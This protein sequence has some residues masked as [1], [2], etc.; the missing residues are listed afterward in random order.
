[1]LLENKEFDGDIDLCLSISN[2]ALRIRVLF[3]DFTTSVA[4]LVGVG[5]G[6]DLILY[7]LVVGSVFSDYFS[8]QNAKMRIISQDYS[9]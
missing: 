6:T 8:V 1:M 4:N 3:P 2:S 9:D 7:L 5:R